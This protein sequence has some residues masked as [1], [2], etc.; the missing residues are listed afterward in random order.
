[1]A[2]L[3]KVNID[4]T[5]I[6]DDSSI[7]DPE[8]LYKWEYERVAGSSISELTMETTSLVP[9][10]VTLKVGQ[11]IEIWG[12]YTTS[13]DKK[14]FDGFV[15]DYSPEAGRIKFTCKDKMWNLIRRNVN[16]V[17]QLSDPQA[18]QISEIAKD[19]IETYGGLTA[20]VQPTGTNPGETV[21]EFRCIHTDI[22]ERLVALAN[23]VGY[24]I[25]YDP[26]TDQ[27][28][29]EQGGL[30]DSGK[31]LT[32]GSNIITVPTW[33][34]DTSRM[35]NDLRVDGAVS[36]TAIRYPLSGSG[37]IGTT[38][39][40]DEDGILLPKTPESV[41]LI[42]DA[43]STPTTIREGGTKDASTTHFYYVDRENRIVR[44]ANTTTFTTGHYAI[45]NYTW[46]APAPIRMTNPTSIT[47]YGLWEK[48]VTLSD[49][50][51]IADAEV[52]TSE[53]LATF[54]IPFLLGEFQIDTTTDP[55][56]ELGQ[57]VLVVDE[58]N[59]PQINQNL[60][61]TGQVIKYP[62][63]TQTIYVGDESIRLADWQMD[64]ENRLKRIEELLSLQNQDLILELRD[65]AN[66]ITLQPRYREV[67]VLE[68]G[69]DTGIWGVM[70]WGEKEWS[71][72]LNSIKFILGSGLFGI[73]GTSEIGSVPV[74]PSTHWIGQYTDRYEEEFI[75]EDFKS[76]ETTAT[77]SNTDSVTFTAG[78]IAQSTSVDF[79]NGLITQA[80]LTSTTASGSFQYEMTANGEDWET[81][82]SG[83]T[84]TFTETGTDLR[85]RATENNTSTG[86]IT[87]IIIT[88]YH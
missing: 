85:W 64:V 11:T 72:A 44:P 16:K 80:R 45:V 38:T 40:F 33:T 17:Y 62:G 77:W 69:E 57:K 87:K 6:K 43:N 36:E 74:P 53:I 25:F 42:I 41:E 32:V 23:A 55:E 60:V 56:V 58:V 75:D 24:V 82:T 3:T 8:Q 48:Q 22:W 71:D 70:N 20:N 67:Q 27:V 66:E 5:T 19:L 12:G 84:H 2:F 9:D 39:D 37:Q 68:A 65:F 29:F 86:E 26:D 63:G 15:S 88:N 14:I 73:L 47:E 54:S 83:T 10:L 81:V 76:E 21:A 78:Q 50:Q 35:V 4:G 49:I 52:R 13:T 30:I 18:G 7:T 79:N 34:Y 1:M 59:N 31:T 61:I 46:L 28:H 51:S